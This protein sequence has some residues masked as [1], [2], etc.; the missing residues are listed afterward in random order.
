MQRPSLTFY[1]ADGCIPGGAGNPQ[2]PE[3][4]QGMRLTTIERGGHLTNEIR[5]VV[6]FGFD[7]VNDCRP[8]S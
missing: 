3:L 8:A 1:I 6:A 2:C 5:Q 7:Q 4:M